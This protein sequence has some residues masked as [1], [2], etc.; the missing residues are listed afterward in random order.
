MRAQSESIKGSILEIQRIKLKKKCVLLKAYY[1]HVAIIQ[2][3][4]KTW[5]VC[6]METKKK[7][8]D[9]KFFYNDKIRFGTGKFENFCARF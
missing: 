9:D 5:H 3:L 1:V 6:L 4:V 7:K 8:E 2:A